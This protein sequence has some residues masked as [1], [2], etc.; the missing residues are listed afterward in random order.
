MIYLSL[1]SNLGDRR[2]NLSRAVALIKERWPDS[3]ARVSSPYESE[4]WGYDSSHPYI[5]I[6]VALGGDAPLAGGPLALLRQLQAI[7]RA[8]SPAPHRNADGTYADRAIDIDIISIDG[9][10]LST[11]ELT[12]PH[13]RAHLRPFVM[14]PLRELGQ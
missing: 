9:I 5:N 10:D 13:P 2:E 7:E 4:P 11:P 6:A 3:P 1:G 8:I 14:I 12:L